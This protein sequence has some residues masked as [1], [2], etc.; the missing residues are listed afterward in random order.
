MPYFIVIK[1]AIKTPNKKKPHKPNDLRGLILNRQL[2][3]VSAWY[4]SVIKKPSRANRELFA[5]FLA[6]ARARGRKGGAKFSLTKA[7]VRLAQSAMGQ[8]ETVI[9]KLCKELSITKPTLYRY[10]APNGVLREYGKRVLGFG[11]WPIVQWKGIKWCLRS[12]YLHCVVWN[13][14]QLTAMNC[15]SPPAYF[16]NL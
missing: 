1:F 7:Q 5:Y 14:G 12:S 2:T 16:A 3:Q 9:S 8:K 13:G 15:Q 4:T 6:S 10:V 11:C